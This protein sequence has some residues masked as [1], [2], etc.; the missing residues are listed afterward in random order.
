MFSSVNACVTD[1]GAHT[2]PQAPVI[3]FDALTGLQDSVTKPDMFDAD[4]D[5]KHIVD[6]MF[7]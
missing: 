1:F 3:E 6:D 2:G 7:C 4:Q 5:L